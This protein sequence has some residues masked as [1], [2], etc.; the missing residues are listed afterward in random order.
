[1]KRST[2]MLLVALLLAAAVGFGAG[3]WAR[4]RTFDTPERRAQRAA[5]HLRDAFRDLT[6]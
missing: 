3:W 6:R 5:E 1:M 4:D 2:L